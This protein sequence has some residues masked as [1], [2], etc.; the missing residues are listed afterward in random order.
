MKTAQEYLRGEPD[1]AWKVGACFPEEV[2]FELRS[3]GLRR[4][5]RVSQ[6]E[7][8]V[9]WQDLAGVRREVRALKSWQQWLGSAV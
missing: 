6:G 8:A 3:E 2:T 7:G 5:Y 1:L 9:Q 4:S